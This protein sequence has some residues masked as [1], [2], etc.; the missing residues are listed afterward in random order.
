MPSNLLFLPTRKPEEPKMNNRLLYRRQFLLSLAPIKPF[1]DWK[2]LQ[3]GQYYLYAHPDLEVNRLTDPK[4]TLV[5]L[6]DIYDSEE[7]LKGN[8]DILEDIIASA[9]SMK[10]FISRIKRYAGCYALLAKSDS[11]AIF[12]HDARGL[13][14]IYYCTET[15]QIICGSQPNLVA[16][17]SNPEIKP[18]TDHDLLDFYNNHLWD[19]RW[20]GDETY[21]GGVKHLLP[22]H[23]LDINKCEARRYWPNEPVKRLQLDEAVSKSSTFLQG[24]MKAIVHRHSVMMAVTAGT[25]SRILLAASKG[26]L[27]KIYCFVNN[28]NLGYSHPDVSVPFKI[29][30]KICIPFHVHDVSN[31]VDDEF[32]RVFFHNTFLAGERILPSIYNVFFKKH[33]EKVLILGVSEIGRTF[34]GKA[35]RRLNSYRMAC[36]LEYNECR[37]VN[38]QCEKLVAQM[39]PLS[40]KFGINVMVLLYWEQRLGNWGATRNSESLIAIEKIDPFNSH[41]LYEIFLGVDEKFRNYLESPPVFFREMIRHMWPDLLEWPVNPPY[42]IQDKVTWLLVELGLYELYTELRYQVNYLK[43]ISR[44]WL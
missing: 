24:I 34:Y 15:N 30:K 16:E 28:H 29:F 33:R 17:F 23:Y 25:D 1:A 2:C 27:D 9:G 36:L 35:P 19:S 22:N 10:E 18:T 14:E 21:F 4:K 43:H 44:V 42:T 8:A 39:Q 31:D 40:K 11:A 3:I 32:R 6:G 26:L 12:V 13:R 37:Y 7:P 20:V 38:K 41:L 5:L